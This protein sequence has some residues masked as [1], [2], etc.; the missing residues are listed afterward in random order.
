MTDRVRFHLTLAV[1]GSISFGDLLRIWV[2]T[3]AK[4]T[5]GTVLSF[6][7]KFCIIPPQCISRVYASQTSVEGWVFSVPALETLN[8]CHCRRL[9]RLIFPYKIFK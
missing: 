7:S 6:H 4:F 1:E 8:L 5:A 2:R 9:T 3:N